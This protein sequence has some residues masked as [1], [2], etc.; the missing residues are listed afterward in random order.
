MIDVTKIVP[1]VFEGDVPDHM[2]KDAFAEIQKVGIKRIAVE[3]NLRISR[4]KAAKDILNTLQKMIYH[5]TRL[6]LYLIFCFKHEKYYGSFTPKYII[7]KSTSALCEYI[8]MGFACICFNEDT[9]PERDVFFK[10][11]Q[12]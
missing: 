3:V 12:K 8:K 11:K 9:F 6:R 4:E 1:W 10:S 2:I 5:A 7:P